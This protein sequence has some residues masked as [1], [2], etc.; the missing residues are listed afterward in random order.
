MKRLALDVEQLEVESFDT[1]AAP[2]RRGTVQGLADPEETAHT[3]CFYSCGGTCGAS[4]PQ[5]FWD[6]ECFGA[7]GGVLG[8][9][10]AGPQPPDC[11]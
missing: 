9:E 1:A 2:A 11:V 6:V 5:S 4:P 3:R 7:D 10:P 8:Y